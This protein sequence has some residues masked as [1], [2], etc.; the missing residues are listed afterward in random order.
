MNNDKLREDITRAIA[1]GTAHVMDDDTV[2]ILKNHHREGNALHQLVEAVAGAV[3]QPSFQQRV[4]PWMMECF[5]P[6]ISAD[7][8]ERNHRFLEEA[9]ELVQACGC[10]MSEAH[11]LVEYV[12]NRPVGEKSQEV[13]GVRVTLSALC[14]A[15]EIN[16]DQAAETELARINQP[17]IIEKIR[18]KQAA[19]P[20][21]SPL[22]AGTAVGLI[23]VIAFA[24]EIMSIWP[25]G[26]VDGGDLQNIAEKH[27]L[28]TPETF[29]EP[30]QESGCN[31]S[32]M[33]SSDEWNAGVTCYRK[34]QILVKQP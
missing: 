24:Q 31:C 10:T 25:H 1:S 13:G 33:W 22:P 29:Y 20:K 26:D 30:C 15:Q 4:Q 17:E 32:G 3:D 12:F 16:E 19:K 28:L 9:L 21:H 8:V 7:A 14:L 5:G 34:A 6:E 11:Q 23:N 27:G 18:A 2:T